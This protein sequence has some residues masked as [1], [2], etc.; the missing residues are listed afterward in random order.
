MTASQ[1]LKN[2]NEAWPDILDAWYIYQFWFNLYLQNLKAA[3][4]AQYRKYPPKLH[5]LDAHSA[6][7]LQ[8]TQ[9]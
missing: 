2:M 1:Q 6:K 9:E 4:V 8:S 3:D 7:L 5:L